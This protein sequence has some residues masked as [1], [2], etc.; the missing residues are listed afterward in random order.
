[1]SYDISFKVQVAGTDKFVEVGDC[2]ANITYNVRKII[3]LSTGLPWINCAN[4]GYCKDVM[5]CIVEGY[6]E[7]LRNPEKYKPYESPNGWGTVAGV[8][9]FFEYLMQAWKTYCENNDP[10]IVNAT[11]FWIE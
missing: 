10:D 2:D 11:T 9:Y 8:K 5:P 6:A 1:M 3:E 7:L 4:N